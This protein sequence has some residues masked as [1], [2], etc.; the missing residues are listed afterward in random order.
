MTYAQRCKACK[1]LFVLPKRVDSCPSCAAPMPVKKRKTIAVPAMFSMPEA[2]AKQMAKDI[3]KNMTHEEWRRLE[4]KKPA[5]DE[6]TNGV[7]AEFLQIN[8]EIAGLY[9]LLYGFM[10]KNTELIKASNI[11][12]GTSIGMSY[13]DLCDFGFFC[14]EAE[15]TLDELRKEVKA[16]KELCGQVIAIRKTQES[17]TDPDIKLKVTGQYAT[18]SPDVRMQAKQP[19]FK[20]GEPNEDYYKLTD[21]FKV[22]REVA[23]M[24]IFRL[25]WK[26]TGDFITQLA[27]DGHKPP[28]GFGKQYPTYVTTFRRRRKT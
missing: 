25:S 28:E 16:R 4:P 15:N 27:N 14:R 8:E 17:L 19:S 1:E 2:A 20:V 10:S 12:G 26:A 3:C 24:G 18:G 23:A 5:A 9:T 21:Y 22:P 6:N 7:V 11:P 13:G